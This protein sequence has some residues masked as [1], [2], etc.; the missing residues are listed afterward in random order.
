MTDTI[1]L[2]VVDDQRLI[3][4]GLVMLLDSEDGI[5]VVGEAG[6]G[7]AGLDLVRA[8]R[9]DVV[10]MDVRMPVMDGIAA[11]ER[12]VLDSSLDTRVLV[13]TTFDTDQAVIDAMRA[14][15]SGFL[16][17]DAE[18]DDIVRAVRAV[19]AG[20]AVIA[21]SAMRRLLD[22]LGPGL[23]AGLAAGPGGAAGAGGPAPSAAAAPGAP[24]AAGGAGAARAVVG[25]VPKAVQSLTPREREVLG[26]IGAGL[27]NAEIA[28][29]LFLAEATAK[30]HVHRVL[31]KLAAR[32]RVQAALIAHQA[33][34][35]PA[36]DG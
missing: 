34:L 5:E 13:L 26:L 36:E 32:D 31:G 33:G 18:P 9:P 2:A 24:V 4:A 25:T 16:L 20:D 29:R 23:R 1:R 15:A 10:L 22:A 21:P 8:E 11:T 30:T 12:I 28:E 19:A 14:G 7:K 17:K 6:D 3:R 35:V 27:T